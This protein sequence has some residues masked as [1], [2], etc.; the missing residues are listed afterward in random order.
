M[1]TTCWSS[2]SF[3][4][5]CYRYNLEDY[6]GKMLTEAESIRHK[7]PPFVSPYTWKD[8][9]TGVTWHICT[10]RS[11]CF[12][13]RL[14]EF[15]TAKTLHKYSRLLQVFNSISALLYVI[16]VSSLISLSP[17]NRNFCFARL[18]WWHV[19]SFQHLPFQILVLCYTCLFDLLK[20]VKNKFL[21]TLF[22]FS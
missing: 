15:F 5:C 10:L 16:F 9:N 17:V 18:I 19:W 6:D 8:W 22:V 21:G 20:R 7:L 1:S 4:H 2:N 11:V 14:Y 3:D 12:V 13:L